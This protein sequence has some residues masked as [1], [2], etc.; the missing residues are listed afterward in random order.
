MT[1]ART[2]RSRR[3]RGS[4]GA[5]RGSAAR[6]RPGDVAATEVET[7][8]PATP[9][10]CTASM[11]GSSSPNS[12]RSCATAS[13]RRVHPERDAGR[14]TGQQHH[15]AEDEHGAHRE[16]RDEDRGPAD[17]VQQHGLRLEPQPRLRSDS[18]N[19]S[20]IAFLGSPVMPFS[21]TMRLGRRKR[22]SAAASCGELARRLLHQR[23]L[24]LRSTG[25]GRGEVGLQLLVV[26]ARVVLGVA[27]HG[28][29]SRGSTWATIDMS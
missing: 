4:P 13:S 8:Q 15:E 5:G 16:A 17:D 12:A 26:V 23:H 20:V 2:M 7:H 6:S 11:S 28:G 25:V 24:L 27:E 18:R 3:A 21:A 29:R 14:V 19:D 22:K 1:T 10:R 9:T